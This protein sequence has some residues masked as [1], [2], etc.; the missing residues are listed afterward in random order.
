M[1]ALKVLI[2]ETSINDG[3]ARHVR[4][5]K[6]KLNAF[7]VLTVATNINYGTNNSQLHAW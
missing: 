7:Q 4:P 3:T 6:R 1:D 5:R 2:V